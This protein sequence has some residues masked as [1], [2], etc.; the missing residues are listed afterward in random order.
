MFFILFLPSNKMLFET[1]ICHTNDT[2]LIKIYFPQ[3]LSLPHIWY[4]FLTLSSCSHYCSHC[5]LFTAL[6]TPS[7]IPFQGICPLF[8]LPYSYFTEVLK[9]SFLL[10]LDPSSNTPL[11]SNAPWRSGINWHL[12]P[13]T[14]FLNYSYLVV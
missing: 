11:S 13:V 4:Y 7:V 3:D 8:I 6:K 2:D 12:F 10:Q 1:P 14:C 9:F 5:G